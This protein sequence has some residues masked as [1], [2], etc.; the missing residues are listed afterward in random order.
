MVNTVIITKVLGSDP[1]QDPLL[2]VCTSESETQADPSVRVV[3][4]WGVRGHPAGT[5]TGPKII[6]D[7]MVR[8]H[9]SQCCRY[10]EKQE[11]GA[12]SDADL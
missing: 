5:E 10:I 1:A 6:A 4:N 7:E 8:W 11:V 2:G 9:L 12:A 3:C